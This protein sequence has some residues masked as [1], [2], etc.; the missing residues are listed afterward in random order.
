M[1]YMA[2]GTQTI[3]GSAGDDEKNNRYHAAKTQ[4]TLVIIASDFTTAMV[5]VLCI[6]LFQR[7]LPE[8]VHWYAYAVRIGLSDLV[9]AYRYTPELANH[10]RLPKAGAWEPQVGRWMPVTLLGHALELSTAMQNFNRR[11]RLPEEIVSHIMRMAVASYSDDIG[12]SHVLQRKYRTEVVIMIDCTVQCLPITGQMY[13][14]GASMCLPATRAHIRLTDGD[15][16]ENTSK[17]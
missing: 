3:D 14:Q 2:M 13:A 16:H 11:M 5:K 4:E 10:T 17:Q 6:G 1:T 8:D 15:R 12:L 9:D 7:M